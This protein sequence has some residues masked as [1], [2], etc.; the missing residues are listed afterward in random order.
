MFAK[1]SS[2]TDPIEGY[3]GAIDAAVRAAC[4]YTR[5]I[6]PK[7][8]PFNSQSTF[9]ELP[10]NRT[11]RTQDGG[12][13]RVDHHNTSSLAGGDCRFV[14]GEIAARQEIE[15][16]SF[17]RRCRPASRDA[18]RPERYTRHGDGRSNVTE[19]NC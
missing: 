5:W 12:A 17:S 16:V 18:G 4:A 2:V 14:A 3:V 6:T 8:E 7:V 10:A 11:Y 1:F 19:A 13:G 15:P 9:P